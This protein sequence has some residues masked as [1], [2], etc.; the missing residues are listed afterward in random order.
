MKSE[1][2]LVVVE[3]FAGSITKKLSLSAYPKIIKK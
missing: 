3:G 1:I 2:L